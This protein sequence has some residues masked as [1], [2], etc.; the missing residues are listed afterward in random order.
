MQATSI[1]WSSEKDLPNK[2]ANRKS[3]IE[4]PAKYLNS[5]LD[6]DISTHYLMI[7]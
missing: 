7:T 4:T 6:D 2:F 1:N 5:L 3:I